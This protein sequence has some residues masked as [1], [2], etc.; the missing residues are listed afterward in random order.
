MTASV[1]TITTCLL[2]DDLRHSLSPV[3]LCVCN[4]TLTH[5]F[6]YMIFATL[7]AMA[8]ALCYSMLYGRHR[9]GILWKQVAKVASDEWQIDLSLSVNIVCR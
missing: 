5:L 4:D 3:R 1:L 8:Y 7:H 9:L 6:Y 2:N